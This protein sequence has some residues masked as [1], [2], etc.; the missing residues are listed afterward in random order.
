MVQT[1][2]GEAVMYVEVAIPAR[3]VHAMM[4]QDP[5]LLQNVELLGCDV[6]QAVYDFV[7]R[8]RPT[9]FQWRTRE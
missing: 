1:S 8:V 3:T 2:D 6:R 5:L 9:Y 7:K 4:E